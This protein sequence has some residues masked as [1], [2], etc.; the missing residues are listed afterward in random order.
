MS[1]R[2]NKFATELDAL[3]SEGENLLLA[4]IYDCQKEDFLKSYRKS[5]NNDEDKVKKVIKSL[6]NFKE[7]YQAWYS[8]AQSLIKHVMPDRFSDFNS[9][10][11]IPK[12][13]KNIDFQS[14]VIRDYLQGLQT[15]RGGRVIA[16]GAAAIPEFIQ[17]LNM[18]KAAKANLDSTL[19]D[20]KGVLQADLF[21][22][23][24]E[25][26]SALAKSGYLRAAGAIC[27]VV[28]E[29]HLQHVCQ[30]HSIKIAKKSPGI[31]DL[32]QML[33]SSSIIT[34]AQERFIQSLA[35]T[36]NVCSHSKGR[37]PTKEEIDQLVEGTGKVLKT[38]F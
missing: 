36:R 26:A 27:G 15:S 23:E 20:L 8:K 12:G 34:L 5:L 11:D 14:Y 13:R 22:S 16:D 1:E 19:M 10:F 37:E 6:P 31:S 7:N 28:I 32:S 38:I 4:M 3:I 17:Q 35:D 18:V 33:K 29:K 2:S 9:Y 21:D 25:T 24:V 30:I